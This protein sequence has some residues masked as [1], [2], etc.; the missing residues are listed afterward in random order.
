[1]PERYA[2]RP[3]PHGFSVYDVTT[4]DTVMIAATSQ[5]GLSREDAEHTATMLNQRDERRVSDQPTPSP[6]D[7]S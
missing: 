3:D 5:A 6:S 7:V 1:M 2:T 4:G